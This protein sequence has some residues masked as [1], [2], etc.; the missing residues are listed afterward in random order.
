M[1]VKLFVMRESLF[2]LV[3][4]SIDSDRNSFVYSCGLYYKLHGSAR[5]I[6][7]KSDVIRK[8]S[9]HDARRGSNA[10]ATVED[11]PS[12]SPGVSRRASPAR[13]PSP[14]LAPDSTTTLSYDYSQDHLTDAFGTQSELVGAL[15]QDQSTATLFQNTFQF[16]FPGPYH[17]DYLLQMYSAH[18]QAA[19]AANGATGTEGLTAFGSPSVGTVDISSSPGNVNANNASHSPVSDMDL[20][21]MSPRSTKR[22][23][24]S[25]DS[26]SE[27]PSSAVSFSSFSDGYSPTSSTTSLSSRSS[28]EFPFTSYATTSGQTNNGGAGGN[29][30]SGP[31][32]RGS[33]NTFWHPPMMPQNDEHTS[34]PHLGF[35]PPML[36]PLA[37]M[38]STDTGVKNLSSGR[39]D[40]RTSTTTTTTTTESNEGN[41]DS[42]MDYLHPPMSLAGV[43]PD[44]DSLFS[45]YL[46]P[47]MTLQEDSPAGSTIV[48]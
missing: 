8:R 42:P 20:P 4:P 47:P 10:G 36:P 37:S 30:N 2:R 29:T 5:P 13:D 28:M 43:V 6:S 11:T 32:L 27:P 12:A 17:P 38:S 15:G 21:L 7:M 41:E 26:A 25:T 35:H 46:H 40:G 34:S 48:V 16:Q 9:R 39:N 3:V 23:R 24:M 31:A 1:K 19:A 44:D 45:A 22:R 14:T 33:G 18:A